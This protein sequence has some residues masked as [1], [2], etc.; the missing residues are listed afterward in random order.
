MNNEYWL[1]HLRA[2]KD[3]LVNHVTDVVWIG[4][5]ETLMDRL[6]H[7]I[8]HACP[9]VKHE[10]TSLN[11]ALDPG[12]G[13]PI[14]CMVNDNIAY[15]TTQPLVGQ[16]G[17]DWD[18]APH[19]YNAGTPYTDGNGGKKAKWRVY[20]VLFDIRKFDEVM[21]MPYR[22]VDEINKGLQP[23]LSP[24]WGTKDKPIMAGMPLADF[25]D[26]LTSRSVGFVFLGE[27]KG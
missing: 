4:P 26:E 8:A 21:L 20:E 5:G 9:P 1:K 15:F 6:E 11:L 16:T 17:D 10:Q 25:L 13:E 24:K 14:L 23:W 22:S 7:I 12:T 18:D 2:I 27:Y 3:D 19:Q